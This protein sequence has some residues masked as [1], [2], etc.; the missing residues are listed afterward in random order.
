METV[1]AGRSDP[2]Y[3]LDN[4]ERC[5]DLLETLPVAKPRVAAAAPGRAAQ[6]RPGTA[7][8]A[9]K[10]PARA[11]ERHAGRGR[12]LG[13]G[14]RRGL[15]RGS[16]GRDREHR[17]QSAGLD[18]E[19]ATNSEA[20]IAT[21]RSFHTLKGSGRMVGAQLIGE[22]AWSIENLLNRLINQTLEPTPQHDRVHR[23][24]RAKR[25]R[26]C[27]SSSRSVCRRRSTCSC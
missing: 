6:A 21:R 7:A 18:R 17:A 13:S 26:S 22:F 20:L 2:W 5:L 9:A 10:K 12:S 8:S 4:A 23:W 24:R 1:S 3:M 15:H 25:C 14:A 11:A 27:S 19:I 16:Q